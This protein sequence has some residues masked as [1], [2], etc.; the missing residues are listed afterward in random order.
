MRKWLILTLT[1]AQMG[2]LRQVAAMAGIDL[3]RN[4]S[5]TLDRAMAEL[6]RAWSEGKTTEAAAIKDL[7]E[8]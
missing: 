6:E 2:T 1:E 5:E 8:K 7:I 3:T 4:D